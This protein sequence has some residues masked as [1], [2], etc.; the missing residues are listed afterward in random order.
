MVLTNGVVQ[1]PDLGVKNV[2]PSMYDDS[3]ATDS[4]KEENNDE[5]APKT[6][7]DGENMNASYDDE[8]NNYEDASDTPYYGE[9][10]M[11]IPIINS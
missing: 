9:I 2:H 3:K 5:N 1:D 7:Y 6:P 8:L 10:L 4:D 11:L